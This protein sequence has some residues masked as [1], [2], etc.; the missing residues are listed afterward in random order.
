MKLLRRKWD[1]CTASGGSFDERSGTQE[2]AA[3]AGVMT[4]TNGSVWS[5]R[6]CNGTDFPVNTI[7]AEGTAMPYIRRLT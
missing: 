6:D 2:L 3:P 1:A 4:M 7:F 5:G